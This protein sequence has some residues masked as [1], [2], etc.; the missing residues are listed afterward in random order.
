MKREDCVRSAVTCVLAA[1][2]VLYS[3]TAFAQARRW[4]PF[5][6]DEQDVRIL[7]D[8]LNSDPDVAFIIPNG[9]LESDEDYARAIRKLLEES[10]RGGATSIVTM[11]VLIPAIASN[12]VQSRRWM[13]LPMEIMHFGTGLP[14]LCRCS[15]PMAGDIN[16][17]PTHSP[18]GRRKYQ[19][20]RRSGP[21][22]ARHRQPTSGSSSG[23]AIARTH[24]KNGKR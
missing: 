14:D 17:F 4:L 23:L 18:D 19:V 10:G 1:C 11:D 7:L 20:V 6:V 5:F 9:P 15:R 8:R 12:G 3:P 24:P 22:L 16:Q 21:I 2:L 13:P